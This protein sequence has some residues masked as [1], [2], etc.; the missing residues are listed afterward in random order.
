MTEWI[1]TSE[2]MP[3]EDGRYLVVE[4]HASGYIWVGVCSLRNGKW[5]ISN[6]IAWDKLPEWME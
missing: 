1:K 3:D 2:R 5:D 6:V 4:K